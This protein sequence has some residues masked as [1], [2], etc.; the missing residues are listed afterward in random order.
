[1][2]MYIVNWVLFKKY[3]SD[4]IGKFSGLKLSLFLAILINAS[5]KLLDKDV[6][7]KNVCK[8]ISFLDNSIHVNVIFNLFSFS[9]SI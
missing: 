1:M 8:D 2:V 9:N 6:L 4:F 5:I 7:D 3:I